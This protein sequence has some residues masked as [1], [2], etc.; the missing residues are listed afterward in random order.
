VK[1][2]PVCSTSASARRLRRTTAHQ[3]ANTREQLGEGER[4]DKIVVGA[5]VET[6]DPILQRVARREDEHGCLDTLAAQRGENLQAVAT[7]KAEIQKD[8]VERLR[9]D[10]KER[11]LAGPFN[12]YLIALAFEALTQ[13][14]GNLLF[15]FD[16]K[17]SHLDSR[18]RF[19][20]SG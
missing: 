8:Q 1:G 20:V 19:V 11:I 9:R 2:A 3:R 10:A 16:D 6:G 5:A 14:V 17:H 18:W 13:R 7:R 15:V 4:L 12:D